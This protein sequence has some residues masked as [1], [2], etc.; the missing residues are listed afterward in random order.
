V[1]IAPYKIVLFFFGYLF[2]SPS[3]FIDYFT[4]FPSGFRN[5]T[6]KIEEI[7]P[8]LNERLPNFDDVTSDLY[9]GEIFSSQTV[10]WIVL[11]VHVASSYLCYIFGKF[12]CK[13]HI[14]VF[15]F[16]LPINLTVPITISMLI[17]LC[18]LR[19]TDVCVY[20]GFLPDYVFF[21]MPQPNFFFTY[22][23]KQ[24]AWIWVFWLFSQSWVSSFDSR[25]R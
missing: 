22:I 16:S 8:I 15:S 1:I 7:K 3:Q 4:N 18:G 14:Q 2:L 20:H 24:F 11:G 21:R 25:C 17:V 9:S 10:I 19:E 12:A 5:H 13:V 6:I 23:Y